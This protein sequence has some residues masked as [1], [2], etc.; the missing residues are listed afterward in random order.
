MAR[1]SAQLR[2][3]S[4]QGFGMKC[5]L[6]NGCGGH[7][8]FGSCDLKKRIAGFQR[9]SEGQATGGYQ[10]LNAV[11]QWSSTMFS[12]TF[13]S[14]ARRQHS[15]T[16]CALRRSDT[17]TTGGTI[18]DEVDWF[19]A[20]IMKD[21]TDTWAGTFEHWRW[22]FLNHAFLEWFVVCFLHVTVWRN[23]CHMLLWNRSQHPVGTVNLSLEEIT[24]SSA[25]RDGKGTYV[26]ACDATHWLRI[27]SSRALVAPYKLWEVND[28]CFLFSFT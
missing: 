20:E 14:A 8:P 5:C 21:S 16:L 1:T 11:L 12:A 27:S 2:S 7:W 3:F 24:T 9:L 17:T 23:C 22:Y 25:K 19:Q 4:S 18:G 13:P 15:R 10:V 26:Q 28:V 6:L